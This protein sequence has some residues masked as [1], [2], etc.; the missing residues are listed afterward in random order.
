[1]PLP[2]RLLL[3]ALL[4]L[5]PAALPAG[6]LLLSPVEVVETK[7]LFGRIESR[8]VVPA[9]SRIGGTVT[10][11]EVSEGDGV[12]ADRV[13]ARI[14]DE[15][16]ELQLSAAEARL[17]AARSELE[18]AEAELAR[19][20]QLLAR[21]STTAQAVDRVRTALSV[22]RNTVAELGSA[23]SV[24]LQQMAEG[25][26]LAPAA[27]R[28]LSVPIRLG[29][30][31]LAG[32][33]VA[34]IAA[35]QVFLRLQIPER[36]ANGLAVGDSVTIGEGQTEGRIEKLYPLIENGRV[37]ADVAVEGLSDAFIGQRILVQ[38]RVGARQAL[39]VPEAAIRRRAGLDL[40]EIG[41]EGGTR[42][43]SVVPGPVVITEAG[44][45]VEIL[46][47]LRSGDTVLVP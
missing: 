45:M 26:V 42:N 46:S 3:P 16:L 38:V 24:I 41:A 34:T 30:V 1:M 5:L 33:E 19:S 35:G 29:E 12:A 39:A 2:L 6:E 17:A 10:A 18:N 47:G 15:K 11:L 8:F 31:V 14:T 32:E 40:V 27:G 21:G 4:A 43:V 7:A 44:P 37:T 25:E 28:V 20:E 23:R 13:I 22:A 36:H 9:R